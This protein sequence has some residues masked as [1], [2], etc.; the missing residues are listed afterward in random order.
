MNRT[1]QLVAALAASSGFHG[2]IHTIAELAYLINTE[3]TPSFRKLLVN[4][5][6]K[7]ILR[8]ITKGLYESTLT[9]PNPSTALY[10]IASKLREGHLNYISLESQLSHTGRI[11]QIPMDRLTIMTKGR[12]GIFE[13]PYGTIEFTHSKKTQAKLNDNLYFDHDIQ[14]FRATADQAL[15]D[16]KNCQRNLHMVEAIDKGQGHA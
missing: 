10:K 6:K 15:A 3:A 5:T 16:L 1:E 4:F 7:G 11:S 12:T 8:R 14:M 13:T 9:P 2:G